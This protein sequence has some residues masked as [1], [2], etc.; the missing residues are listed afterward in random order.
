M[1]NLQSREE[2]GAEARRHL[3]AWMHTTSARCAGIVLISVLLLF[4]IYYLACAPKRYNLTVGS[5][6]RQ[7]ITAPRDVVDEIGTEEKRKAAASAVEPTYHLAEG[8]SDEVMTNLSEVFR[9]LS[10]VQQYG[11]TL[12]NPEEA[13]RSSFTDDEIEYAQKLVTYFSLGRYQATTLLRTQTED[14]ETMVSTVTRAVENALNTGIREGKTSDAITTVQ[15]IVGYR[16]DISLVQN[17]LPTVLRVCIQP[18]LVIDQEATEKAK[19]KA[20]EAIDPVVYLTGQNILRDGEV[21]TR[22]QLAMLKSLGMLE[23]DSVD[24]TGYIGAGSMILLGVVVLVFLLQILAPQLLHDLRKTLVLMSVLVITVGLCALL[25]RTMNVYLVPVSL[26]AMLLMALLGWETAVPVMAALS[27]ML[28]GLAAGG[29]S[30]TLTEMLCMVLMCLSG[31]AVAIRVLKGKAQRVMMLATGLAVGLTQSLIVMMLALLASTQWQGVYWNALYAFAGG[32]LC[33]VIEIV[34]QPLYESLFRLATPSKLLE[35]GNPNH[36]LMRKLLLEAPGTY[37]HSII[38]ANLAEAAAEKVGANPLLARTGAYFHDVGKLKRPQYFK[39][40]QTGINPL[41]AQD[42]YVS[43]AIVTTHTRDGVLLAQKYHLPPEIQD[44][45]IQHHGDTPVMFFYHKAVEQANGNPVDIADFRYDGVR[46][47]SKEAAIIM[48]ADTVE[49]AVRTMHDPTPQAIR[50]FIGKLVRGKLDDGQ[51]NDCPLTLHDVDSMCDAFCTVLNGVFHERIEYP[52]TEMP[53]RGFLHAGSTK[54]DNAARRKAAKRKAGDRTPAATGTR[55]VQPAADKASA[56]EKKPAVSGTD[57]KNT[58]ASTGTLPAQPAAD[59]ASAAEK[60]PAVSG[61][62]GKNTAASTG[63]RPAQS[64]V[65]KTAAIAEKKPAASGT[66]AGKTAV[67][68]GT[69][70]MRPVA[71]RD[72]SMAATLPETIE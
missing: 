43:A 25:L 47:T 58:A 42:P 29:S 2:S 45:I 56:A 26:A 18:N 55:L 39:E 4:A 15:Q 41:D 53:K 38:V 49:A 27:V 46:P 17:I 5:I 22:S 28:P 65:D 32:V 40:N 8:V 60:K 31:S 62:D 68:A 13:A 44:I 12:L 37:H 7:T 9:E 57:G 59:K 70:G 19:S 51:L 61:T 36:P 16:V 63:T 14:F 21:V 10:K 34:L 52:D 11:Q 3:S 50:E 35:I 30:S 1:D 69:Q 64:A 48:V 54:Q 71:D 67:P 72:P 20:M 66:D 24:M 33:A 23:S 6:S